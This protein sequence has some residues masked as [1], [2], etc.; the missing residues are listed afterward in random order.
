MLKK[1]IGLLLSV[2]LVSS[3]LSV[4]MAQTKNLEN[5]E[6][7]IYS[8][9]EN[10]M[11][12][13]DSDEKN[14][15]EFK[16]TDKYRIVKL[17]DENNVLIGTLVVNKSTNTL[18]S[19][20]TGKTIELEPE[21]NKNFMGILRA[22]LNLKDTVKNISYKQMA[23]AVGTGITIAGIVA[24][25]VAAVSAPEL[26]GLASTLSDAVGNSWT[27]ISDSVAKRKSGGIRIV[28]GKKEKRIYKQG[29]WTLIADPYI[30]SV[31]TY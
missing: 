11:V 31:K 5:E 30:K 13:I 23:D 3:S 28:I 1:L 14:I 17:T 6:V 16:D 18:Y 19:S 7:N 15:I 25:L 21:N 20:I 29:E 2:M 22:G 26:V 4:S 8:I 9:S 24:V 12:V 10:K 27:V